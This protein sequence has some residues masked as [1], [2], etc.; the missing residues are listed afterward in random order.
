VP[1]T[2]TAAAI[3][4]TATFVFATAPVSATKDVHVHDHVCSERDGERS[5]YVCGFAFRRKAA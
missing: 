1:A 5:I 4:F 2:T 3:S